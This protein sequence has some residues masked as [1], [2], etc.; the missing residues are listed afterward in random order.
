M[1]NFSLNNIESMVSKGKTL[2]VAEDGIIIAAVQD[3]LKNGRTAT[4]YLTHSQ[5]TAIRSWYWTPQMIKDTGLESVSYEEREQIQSKL[6]FSGIKHAYSNRIKCQ[7]GQIY[8]SFEFMQQ[9]IEE[10]GLEAVKSI[11][12]LKDIAVLRVNPRQEAICSN[13]K[14]LLRCPHYYDYSNYGCCRQVIK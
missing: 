1:H 5:F 12:G 14:E 11:F 13:C 8:G 9:G 7:C 3:A 10:H 6:G 2:M 4:F